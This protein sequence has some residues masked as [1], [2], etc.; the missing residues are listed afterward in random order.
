[1]IIIQRT[2]ITKNNDRLA[3]VN[4]E[5]KYATHSSSLNYNLYTPVP[6]DISYDVSIVSKRQ[7]DID[8][9]LGNFIPFFNKDAFV[10]YKHP[11]FEGLF[12]KCQVIMDD[13]I[14]EEHPE[15]FDAFDYDV[16]T[17]KCS[18]TFKTYIFCGNDQVRGEKYIRHQLS[19]I[20]PGEP[21]NDTSDYI[22]VVT[23]TEYDGFIPTIR[24]INFGFY[25]VPVLSDIVAHINWVDTLWNRGID[26]HPYVDRLIWKIDE[27][28]VLTG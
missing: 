18:F 7:G 26:D 23:D 22:S 5:V 19:V 12:M 14:S 28:G 11:K 1:M 2:G 13:N 8:R 10:R 4:N 24:Q 3:N 15:E 21:G 27:S 6:I 17:C 16:I 25:P 9:A 20:P